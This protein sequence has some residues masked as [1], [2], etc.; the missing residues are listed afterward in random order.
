MKACYKPPT[1]PTPRVWGTLLYPTAFVVFYEFRPKS[2]KKGRLLFLIL[3]LTRIDLVYPVENSTPQVLDPLEADRLQEFRGFCAAAAHL[4]VRDDVL[5]PGQLGVTPRQL[6][7]RNE[8]TTRNPA[9]L[10]L[11]RLAHIEDEHVVACVEPLFQVDRC[12]LPLVHWC[13]CS[14][15]RGLW[16][17]AAELFVV[18]QLGHGRMRAAHGAVR[19]L[20]ELQ[21]AET[22]LQ[23]VVDEEAADQRF[24]DTENQL[25]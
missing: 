6:T 12:R 17:D 24:A 8:D 15:R 10:I 16:P 25:H 5:V 18:N 7:Q 14:L 11:V 20:P 4:A 19:I 9:D 1:A 23:C 13:S 21:L 22:H 2:V 3:R